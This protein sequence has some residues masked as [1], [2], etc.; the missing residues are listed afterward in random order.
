MQADFDDYKVYFWR[1][2]NRIKLLAESKTDSTSA[3]V[4]VKVPS[5]PNGDSTIYVYY[6]NGSVTTASSGDNTFVFF[7][8]FL[9]SSID[10]Q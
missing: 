3:I 8:D 9:G 4:W 7:D 2:N 1:W 10:Y 6:G 5:I